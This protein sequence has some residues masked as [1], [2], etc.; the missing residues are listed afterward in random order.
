MPK[1][2]THFAKKLLFLVLTGLF[3]VSGT[4]FGFG[5]TKPAGIEIKEFS[6]LDTATDLIGSDYF[7]PEGYKD[8]HFKLKLNLTKKTVIKAIVLR[9]TDENGKDASQGIWRTNRVTAGWLLGIVQNKTVTTST[10]T[11][12]EN[13]II[14]TGGFHKDT[15]V[16][17]GEFEGNLSFDLYASNNGHSGSIKETQHFVLE[18]ETP[19]GTVSSIPIKYKKPMIVE[20][21]SPAP[22]S[23]PS[24]PPPPASS[25]IEVYFNDEKIQF[26]SAAPIIKNGST[27]VPFRKL[28]ETLGFTVTWESSTEQATGTKD[29][30]V[31]ELTINSSTAKV[32]Q[33][34]ITLS[35]PAQIIEGNTMVPLRFVAENSGYHVSYDSNN[36]ISTIRIDK[37]GGTPSIPSAPS[38]PS[39]PD[40][41]G[42][43]NSSQDT[44]EPYVVKGYIRDIDGNPIAGASVFADN[45]LFYDSNIIG[46]T[47]AN[48]YY[49][50]ELP[51]LAATW[52][53]S[54]KFTKTIN[55]SNFTYTIYADQDQPFAGNS[56]AIR[57]FT[58]KNADGYIY[59]YPDHSSFREDLPTFNMLDV[60]ITLTPTSGA[61]PI[62]RKAHFVNDSVGLDQLP[63][64]R[65]KA[66]ARWL[67]EG[68]DPIPLLIRVENTG[69]YAASV[70]FE[71]GGPKGGLDYLKFQKELE[72]SVP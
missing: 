26:G 2:K 60:E 37:K 49:R 27:L 48:G 13:V 6:L 24:T 43:P 58:W 39:T 22:D 11:K 50:L 23:D 4:A 7:K 57:P 72:I 21:A 55:G 16:P 28:F 34:A 30:L 69:A 56:G 25:T 52:R 53:M 5:E 32:N 20:G 35:E 51:E 41:P 15:T 71:F 12:Q 59:I 65:Y 67:P 14:N 29:G 66:T 42:A 46:Q 33:N 45:T 47:D 31:I 1:L 36:G 40:T 44:V 54:A 3:V 63:I 10:G 62:T 19:E 18:I 17:V 8:G 61:E 70:E 9:T 68:H 64:T 38:T